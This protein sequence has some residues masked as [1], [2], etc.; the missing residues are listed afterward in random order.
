[1]TTV[2]FGNIV[3]YPFLVIKQGAPFEEKKCLSRDRLVAPN[4]NKK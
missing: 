2:I 4:V 1:M 3:Q